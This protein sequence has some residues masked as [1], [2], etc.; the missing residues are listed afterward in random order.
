ML[1]SVELDIVRASASSADRVAVEVRLSSKFRV[2][3]VVN[4]LPSFLAYFTSNTYW[5]WTL[6]SKAA[7]DSIK[8]VVPFIVK[9][10]W[11]P[12]LAPPAF[13][14]EKEPVPFAFLKALIYVN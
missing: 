3:V 8:P 14:S 10:S 7:T 6:K 13:A 12:A 9:E 1:E 5:L 2:R 11:S 4:I